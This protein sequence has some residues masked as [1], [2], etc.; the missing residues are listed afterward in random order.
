MNH[1]VSA[2]GSLKATALASVYAGT[3]AASL[4]GIIL[5]VVATVFLIV[6]ALAV[7]L[8]VAKWKVFVKMGEPGWTALIPFYRTTKLLELVHYP[9]WWIVLLWVPIV[10]L[11]VW[12]LVC[13]RLAEG[14]G[15]GI[16]YTLGLFSL[17]IVFYPL[18]AWNKAAF[19]PSFPPQPTLAPATLW[20]LIALGGSLLYLVPFFFVGALT[21]SP[22]G[23]TT[24]TD[25][26]GFATD[27]RFV[28]HYDEI[29]PGADPM[30]FEIMGAY[31]RDDRAVYSNGSRLFGV[32][33]WRFTV[34]RGG[35]YAIADSEVYYDGELTES[36]IDPDTVEV[37]G[38]SDYAVDMHGVYYRG[39]HIDGADPGTFELLTTTTKIGGYDARDAKHYFSYGEMMT[40]KTPAL[41]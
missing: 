17:P 26:D 14:F 13:R 19:A 24:Y 23:L 33:P 12:F 22:H 25:G 6:I 41:R 31:E 38:E 40:D 37:I 35:Y 32:S 7:F 11:V 8:L 34:L 3:H 39:A 30:T 15:K 28:Y 16:G 21:A 9:L 29:I 4:V 36:P 20:A 27:G 18:L 2:L 5:A 1:L 10:N